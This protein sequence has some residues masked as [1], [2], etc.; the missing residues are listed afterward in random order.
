M[1]E[2]VNTPRVSVVIPTYNR[3][4]YVKKAV[5]SVLAQD[6]TDREIIVVDDGSTD[7]TM[8]VLKAYA[9]R[10][11]VIRQ[12]NAG[13]SAA[14]N[15]GIEAAYG[16]WVAFLDSDDEWSPRKLSVQMRDLARR[17]DLC[18]HFTNV[19]FVDGDTAPVNLFDVRGFDG[20]RGQDSVLDRPLTCVLDD[21][22]VAL[23]SFVAKREVLIE[24]GLFDRRLTIAEDRDLLMRVA[25]RG[26]WGYSADALVVCYR[27]P[28]GLS[29]TRRFQADQDG[30]LAAIVSAMERVGSDERLTPLER[31]RVGIAL[32]RWLFELGVHQRRNGRTAEARRSFN[33]SLSARPDVRSAV[34]YI[35]TLMPPAIA[36]KLLRRWQVQAGKG[37]RA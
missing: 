17:P 3:A 11:R 26:A 13:P 16:L 34:K 23:P 31:R 1:T 12:D 22:I 30:R 28:D 29:L 6:Y 27:R 20:R 2:S 18:A 7:D 25:L 10:I 5:E 14:R 37:F 21:E 15:T 8:G 36:D 32:S 35:L 9:G 19:S 24:A 33:R 4:N